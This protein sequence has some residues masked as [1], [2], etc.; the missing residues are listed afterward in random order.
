MSLSPPLS[1]TLSGLLIH[2]RTTT[3]PTLMPAC[4]SHGL[5]PVLPPYTQFIMIPL[6]RWIRR[7]AFNPLR[8]YRKQ[9]RIKPYHPLHTIP[10]TI[11][12][13]T[14]SPMSTIP[15]HY[16]YQSRHR[17]FSS[18][19]QSNKLHQIPYRWT[20]IPWPPSFEWSPRVIG[21]WTSNSVPTTYVPRM[22]H[23]ISTGLFL[24]N[25]W[26]LIYLHF[27]PHLNLYPCHTS[28]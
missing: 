17:L 14:T 20:S 19:S 23:F 7:P 1:L 22:L 10:T 15:C 24:P 27:L 21:T 11:P 28:R 12:L 18:P 9:L 3:H 2:K 8:P 25:F 13:S 26:M 16:M 6:A 5:P 4:N